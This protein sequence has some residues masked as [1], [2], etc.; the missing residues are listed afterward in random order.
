MVAR[1]RTEQVSKRFF[2]EKK[3]QKTFIRLLIALSPAQT[4]EVF[5]FLFVHKKKT[6]P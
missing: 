2:F 1:R 6:L 3:N 4:D 5:L